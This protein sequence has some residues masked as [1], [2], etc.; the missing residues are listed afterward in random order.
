MTYA[1]P[2]QGWYGPETEPEEPTVPLSHY[3]WILKRHRWKI[4]AFVAACMLATFIVSERV[5]PIYE[6][7]ATI[8]VDRRMPAGILGQ[9]ANQYPTADADQFLATQVKLI[10]SDSVLRPVAEKFHLKTDAAGKLPSTRAQ[11]APVTLKQLKVT[12]PPNTYLL[13]IAYRSPNP[14]LASDV[15]NAIAASYIRHT[16]DI[17]FRSSA[18]LA[19]FMEKQLEE[20]KAKME[21]SGEALAKFER[22]LNVINPE[23]KTNILSSRLLQLNTDYTTAQTDR[24]HKEAA[25]TS[26]RSGEMEAAQV[27]SHVEN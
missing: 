14:D 1:I 19:E 7:T 24:V 17:R 5:T 18:S 13:L 25:Y 9:D 2:P 8:D 15:S 11:N 6:S 26:V 4:L 16:Y 21:T 27:S 10:Q 20:L 12:R 3:L 22:E 23:E